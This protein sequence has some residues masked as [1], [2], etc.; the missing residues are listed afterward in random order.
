MIVS[1]SSSPVVRRADPSNIDVVQEICA[2][3]YI[4]AY[5]AV[6]SAVPKPASEDYRPRIERGEVWLLDLDGKPVGV[7]VLEE[8]SD[9]LLVYSIAVR[10]EQ[11]RKGFGSV[12]L[13]FADQRAIEIGAPEVR[14]YTNQRM[15]QN[16]TLYRRHGFVE[17]GTRPHPS[18]P[19]EVLVDMT[20]MLRPSTSV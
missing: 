15:E 13:H 10:P 7:A 1:N 3:A 19:G 12:L 16:L 17:V 8:R 18:R 4:P 2:A 9:H 20:K 5:L 6:I 14:L 11:Q